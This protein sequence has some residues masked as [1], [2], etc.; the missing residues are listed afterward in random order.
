M[1]KITETKSDQVHMFYYCCSKQEFKIDQ[2]NKL[3]CAKTITG[4]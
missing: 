2:V 4:Q 1:R 3:I